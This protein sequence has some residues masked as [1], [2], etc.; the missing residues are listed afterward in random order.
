MT[1]Q[2][3][4]RMFLGEREESPSSR[5]ASLSMGVKKPL[6]SRSLDRASTMALDNSG[7]SLLAGRFLKSGMAILIFW[8]E[9]ALMSIYIL[10]NPLIG[11]RSWMSNKIPS[12]QIKLIVFQFFEIEVDLKFFITPF[13]A[14][15]ERW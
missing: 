13:V 9:G 10:L 4:K 1:D 5:K 15:W 12:E 11:R 7:C 2:F 3:L 14:L 8:I 6:R